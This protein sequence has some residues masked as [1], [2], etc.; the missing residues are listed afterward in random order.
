MLLTQSVFLGLFIGAFDIAAHSLFLSTFDVKMMARGYIIS[1]IAGIILISLY[2]WLKPRVLFKNLPVIKLIIITFLAF[3]LWFLLINTH[4]K[5]VIFLIFIM[6]GP[7]NIL[8]LLGFGEVT[9]RAFSGQP[10]RKKNLRIADTGLFTGILIISFIIPLIL[11]FKFQLINLLLVS[12]C[13]VFIAMLIQVAIGNKFSTFDADEPDIREK[14]EIDFFRISGF[15]DYPY[16]RSIYSFACLSLLAAFF[17]QYLFMAVTKEQFPVAEEMARFLGL[18]TGSIMLLIIFFRL[19]GFAYILRK[20]GLRN[21]LVSAPFLIAVV[22]ALAIAIGLVTGYTP[23]EFSGFIMLIILLASARL[24]SKLLRESLESPSLKII[25]E[26]VDE[27]IKTQPHSGSYGLFNEIMVVFS[28][29]ILTVVGLF[30]FVRLIHFSLLLLII[31]IIWLYS[32]IRLLKEYRKNIAGIADKAEWIPEGISVLNTHPDL[33]SRFAARLAFRKDYLSLISGDYS[34]LNKQG[35]KWYYAKISDYSKSIKDINL[36]PVLKKITLNTELDKNIRES[37]EETIRIIQEYYASLR[38]GDE[39][40]SDAIRTLSGTRTPQTTEILRLFREGSVESK[41]LAIYMIGKFGIADLLPEVCGSLGTPGVAVEAAEV[42]R[43]SGTSVEDKL[44]RFYVA[45]SGNAKLSK[46]VLQLLGNICTKETT[47]FFFSRLWSNSRQLKEIASKCLINCNFRPTEDEKLRLNQL[48][49]DIIGIITWYLSAKISLVR[50]NDNF[51]LG[52]INREI[53][54]WT[55]F[56]IDILSITYKPA[57]ISRI[58]EKIN[59][60]TIESVSNALEMTDIVVGEPVKQKLIYLLDLVPDE[61]KLKNLAHFY[62]GEIP[63]RKRLQ[64]DIINR[65]Y[66]LISLW[67][68]ACTL[69]TVSRI[70]S[71]DMAES[72]TALLFS[73]EEIIQE[74]AANLIARSDSG[75][76]HAAE[77]RLPASIKKRLDSIICGKTDVKE[78]L[79][80]KVQF[81]ARHFKGIEEDEL[82]TL[83]SELKHKPDLRSELTDLPEGV[84]IWQLTSDNETVKINVYYDGTTANSD[85]MNHPGQDKS[86]YCLPLSAIEQFHFQFPERSSVILKYIDN[87][88]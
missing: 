76:Y 48:S 70:E 44:I 54:R 3:L 86:F 31:S 65:D 68:K 27:K 12:A 22:S 25:Y 62:P 58:I 19:V 38:P 9:E 75:L 26:S 88:E 66:N 39:K 23:A 57:S 72:V 20:Y 2:S 18:F 17:V 67:T 8:T 71:D 63:N 7:L 46:T 37:A 81:L 14:H 43:K 6:Y 55:S 84:I 49:S 32:A 52:R 41:R 5:T 4:S 21:C 69:R 56:L 51:L 35:N 77:E 36:V 40:I 74:E 61:E 87:N 73:P 83:A 30:S 33:K 34:V 50:D 28:G 42:L 29:I 11:F 53:E 15:N 24:I 79:F 64:E 85:A 82:L 45:S 16:L 13:S 78:L 1:G 60:G 10:E 59:T 47:G 80:E